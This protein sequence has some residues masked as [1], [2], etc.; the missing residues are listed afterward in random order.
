MSKSSAGNFFEDFQL[1]T[2][3]DCPTPRVLTDGDRSLYIAFTNDRTPRFCN[4][5]GLVHP[6]IVFHTVLGQTVRPISLNAKANLG[7]AE[8][9]WPTPV[10]VGDEIATTAEIIGLKENRDR[11]SGIVYVRTRGTNQRG[12]TVLQ[13]VRWVMVHKRG[14]AATSYLTNPVTPEIAPHVTVNR[15]PQWQGTVSNAQA[16]GG[17]FWFEDYAVGERIVH[18]DGVTVN[19]SDHMSFTRCYQNTAKVHFD[20]I[21]TEGK[22]LVYGGYPFSLAYAHALNGFENRCGIVALNGGT[23]VSPVY[24]GDTIYAFTD[25]IG[26]EPLGGDSPIG[27]LRCRLIGVKNLPVEGSNPFEIKVPNPKRP[28]EMMYRPEVVLDID[29]W[30]W[31]PKRTH[32]GA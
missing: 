4:R 26:V 24:A 8:M 5:D 13:Y 28:G 2:V 21:R 3:I 10:H 22:P 17:R 14:E 7:Y 6:L 27:A 1:G 16:T 29:Y 15:F 18:L 20:G 12:E 19:Q 9:L 31:M 11:K 32:G 25:L 30:E 23:H